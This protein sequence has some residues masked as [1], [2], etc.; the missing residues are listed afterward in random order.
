MSPRVAIVTACSLLH[1]VGGGLRALFQARGLWESGFHDFTVFSRQP[2][3]RWP[4]DQAPLKPHGP[5]EFIFTQPRGYAL[6]HAHH[7]C[8]LFL[9][10]RIWADLSGWGPLEAGL[11]WHKH[12]LNARAAALFLL[13]VWAVRR[14][15]AKSERFICAAASVQQNALCSLSMPPPS[16]VI[17][18]ALDPAEFTPAPC[19]DPVVGVVGGFTSRW[20]RPALELALRVAAECPE[21][22]FRLIGRIEPRQHAMARQLANVQVLGEADEAG[23]REFFK[24]ISIAL[25]P[26]DDWCRGGGSRLKLLQA[27]AAGLAVVATPAGLEGFEA[28]PETLLGRSSTELADAIRQVAGTKGRQRRGLAL[29]RHIEQN[30]HYLIEGQRL[31]DLYRQAL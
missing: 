24:T 26:Y 2:D 25:L 8:A 27:A 15:A 6:I 29:R 7:N 17:R 1:P 10:G 3:P 23:F 18:N 16:D 19:A 21:V 20:G 13:S 5:A 22:P 30:H 12:P 9:R 11:D 4:F 31:A 28:P 14:L